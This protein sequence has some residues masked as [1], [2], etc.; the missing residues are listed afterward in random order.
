MPGKAY[1][2]ACNNFWRKRSGGDFQGYS[3]KP[4]VY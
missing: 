4:N 1:K 3:R 2:C